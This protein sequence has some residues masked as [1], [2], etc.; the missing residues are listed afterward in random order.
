MERV[1]AALVNRKGLAKM[2]DCSLR[3]V[4][5]LDSSGRLGPR[6][7]RLGRIKRW[8]LDEVRRWIESDCPCRDRWQAMSQEI[9]R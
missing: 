7:I 6:A 1:D 3:H 9:L 8:R 2:L 5:A 4:D